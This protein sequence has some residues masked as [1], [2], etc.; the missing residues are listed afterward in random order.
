MSVIPG[1]ESE[2]GL[3]GRHHEGPYLF[4]LL[5]TRLDAW[6][7]KQRGGEE[8]Q[9]LAGRTWEKGVTQAGRMENGRRGWVRRRMA[10]YS[11]GG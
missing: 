6:E 8:S 4:L 10:N 7:R 1:S 2:E 11:M 3:R 5:R 9:R